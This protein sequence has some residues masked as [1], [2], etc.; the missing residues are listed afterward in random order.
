MRSLSK[1]VLA[2]ALACSAMAAQAG[3]TELWFRKPEK[4]AL[5]RGIRQDGYSC[6]EIRAVYLV[7]AKADGNHMRAVCGTAEPSAAPSSFRLTVRGSGTY[8]V[9]PWSDNATV[10]DVGRFASDFTLRTSLN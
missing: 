3:E 4:I 6:S 7:E 8:R 2:A 10:A 5:A 9:A 1:T